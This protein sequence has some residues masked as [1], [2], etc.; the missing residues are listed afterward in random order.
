MITIIRNI[1][2]KTT[3]CSV[4]DSLSLSLRFSCRRCVLSREVRPPPEGSDTNSDLSQWHHSSDKK[5]LPDLLLK[6]VW[7]GSTISFIF[8]HKSHEHKIETV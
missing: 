7:S 2:S 8:H 5:G 1:M 6:R 4:P 3:I